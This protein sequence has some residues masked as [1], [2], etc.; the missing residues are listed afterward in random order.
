V[1]RGHGYR[2]ALNKVVAVAWEASVPVLA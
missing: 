1:I 2:L